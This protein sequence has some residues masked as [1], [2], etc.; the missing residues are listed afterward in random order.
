L[1]SPS[2]LSVELFRLDPKYEGIRDDSG[3][4]A[5]LERYSQPS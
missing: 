3:F 2:Y 5:L 4:Q 1:A